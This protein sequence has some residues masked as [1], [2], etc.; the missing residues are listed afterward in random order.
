MS[1]HTPS[2]EEIARMLESAGAGLDVDQEAKARAREAM[3]AAFVEA[4]ELD[5]APAVTAPGARTGDD[6]MVELPAP[7][8]TT[9]EPGPAAGR[10]SVAP[11]RRLLIGIAA[12]VALIV[13]GVL[14]ARREDRVSVVMPGPATSTVTTTTDAPN[15]TPIDAAAEAEITM[16]FMEARADYDGETVL[17]LLAPD[18]SFNPAEIAQSVDEVLLQAEWEQAVGGQY[19][20]PSC[21]VS[22]PGR[23]GCTYTIQ[24]PINERLGLGPYEGNVFL[25]EISDGRITRVDHQIVAF[26]F[27]TDVEVGFNSWV[28][29]NHPDDFAA[30]GDG[31]SKRQRLYLCSQS[32]GGTYDAHTEGS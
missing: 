32:I 20:E 19:L 5:S 18:A 11:R 22:A 14:A 30:I 9:I 29:Q 25:L 7:E 27:Y 24:G 26:D 21:G 15:D 23:V 3:R 28:R 16:Q 10:P 12:A 4:V 17:S 31:S 1:E 13:V 2:D 8:D 6:L